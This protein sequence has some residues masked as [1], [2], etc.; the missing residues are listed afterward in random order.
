MVAAANDSYRI[1]TTAATRDALKAI[2]TQEPLATRAALVNSVKV[3]VGRWERDPLN[4]G[5]PLYPLAWLNLEVRVTICGRLA[6]RFAV[7]EQRRIV[8]LVHVSLVAGAG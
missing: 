4:F 1:I 8:Y 6:F 5:E 7:D 2:L 3:A